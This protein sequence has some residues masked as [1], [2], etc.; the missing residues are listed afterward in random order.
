[1]QL[2]V[3]RKNFEYYQELIYSKKN[4]MNLW[5]PYSLATSSEA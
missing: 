5:Q 1:M 3:S 4:S 2:D